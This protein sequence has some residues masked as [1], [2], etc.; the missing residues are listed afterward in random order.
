MIRLKSLAL[1]KISFPTL[2]LACSPYLSPKSTQFLHLSSLA[3]QSH[4]YSRIASLPNTATQIIVLSCCTNFQLQPFAKF[5]IVNPSLYPNQC[6]QSS[7]QIANSNSNSFLVF[8][9]LSNTVHKN[10]VC[11]HVKSCWQVLGGGRGVG[12]GGGGGGL[13]VYK[14]TYSYLKF[15]L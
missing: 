11:Q 10:L 7:R 2:H 3:Y 1:P 6:H 12:V 13:Q 5:A 4:A 14:F 15:F 9:N 8:I